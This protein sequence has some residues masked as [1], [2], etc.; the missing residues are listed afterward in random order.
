MWNHGLGTDY[1]AVVNALKGLGIKVFRNDLIMQAGAS[2]G[3]GN[4][5][6]ISYPVQQS[7]ITAIKNWASPLQAAGI[8]PLIVCS[9]STFQNTSNVAT[10][11]AAIAKAVP[12]LWFEWGNE[13]DYQ[14]SP[15]MSDAQIAS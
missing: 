8:Q 12:G 3:R 6:P 13:L 9:F 1:T 14:L 11:L 10:A 4:A 7:T 2:S 5:N 15:A